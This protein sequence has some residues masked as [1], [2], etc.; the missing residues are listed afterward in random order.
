VAP[1]VLNLGST[2]KQ[3]VIY[4]Y[5]PLYPWRRCSGTHGTEGWIGP[6]PLWMVWKADK[7]VL[8]P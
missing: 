8:Q 6:K 3:V 4:T 2:Q 1:R 7:S 5:R